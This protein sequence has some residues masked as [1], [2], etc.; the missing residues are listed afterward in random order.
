MH[1]I[2]KIKLKIKSL[3]FSLSLIFNLAQHP[4][5]ATAGFTFGGLPLPLAAPPPAEVEA[6]FAFLGGRPRGLPLPGDAFFA[7]AAGGGAK[8]SLGFGGRPR[9]LG[10]PT[11]VPG[12]PGAFGF[13]G[14]PR[15]RLG[16]AL[17]S[18]FM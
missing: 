1:L 12:G 2:N 3:S 11:T 4:T 16:G 10:D 13:G 18:G 7:L 5:G 6:V 9:G 17:G 14:R 15:P 8:G